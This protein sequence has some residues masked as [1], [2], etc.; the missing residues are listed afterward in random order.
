MHY[1]ETQTGPPWLASAFG[2]SGG[3]GSPEFINSPLFGCFAG[4]ERERE[5]ERETENEHDADG[6]RDKDS[7]GDICME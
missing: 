5:R 1:P 4:R 2:F 6:D 7:D 3:G